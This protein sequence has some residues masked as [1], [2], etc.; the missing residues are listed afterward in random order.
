MRR[1]AGYEAHNS[2][3]D[4]GRGVHKTQVDVATF[5]RSCRVN[6]RWVAGRDA[7]RG[8]EAVVPRRARV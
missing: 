6:F 3:P 7:K 8:G 1:M 5:P 2:H 4:L